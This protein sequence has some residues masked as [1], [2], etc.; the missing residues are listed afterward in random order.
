LILGSMLA[1][2]ASRPGSALAGPPA[3]ALTLDAIGS[4][5]AGV[6]FTVRV[7]A[8]GSNG[9]VKT[10]FSG[11]VSLSGLDA[12]PGCSGCSPVIAST[13]ASYGSFTWSNGVGTAQVTAK[14]AT[15]SDT[16]T[17]TAGSA[18]ADS[19]GFSVSAGAL[20]D[21][22][23]ANGSFNGQP[24]DAEPGYPI[25]SVC[26]PSAGA[27]PCGP[28][29]TPTKVQAV[30]AYGNVK[31]GVTIDITSTPS[32]V[33]GGAGGL[34][35]SDGVA[36]FSNLIIGTVGSTAV[37]GGK[38]LTATSGAAT[39]TSNAFSIVNDLSAC[40]GVTCKNNTSNGK[41]LALQRA[42]GRITTGNDF[43]NGTT[44]NV[45]LTTAFA[46]GAD[47]TGKCT[48]NT[49]IGD[50]TDLKIAGLGTGITA[51]HTTMVLVMTSDALKANGITSRGTPSFN[52]CLGALNVDPASTAT[53][54]RAK[55]LGKKGGLT[56]STSTTADTVDHRAWGVPADCGTSGLS[57]SD[58]CIGL[59]TKSANQAQTYLGLTSAEFSELGISENDLVIIIEKGAPWDGKGGV[60]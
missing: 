16:L 11:P 47:T 2:A 38:T 18:T 55:N 19:N 12:S 23:F 17:A 7:T 58:P 24:I 45:R 37:V 54:W 56:N 21:L 13:A 8:Y 31:S 14:R 59:R 3:S 6:P 43:Y 27:N 40:D 1:V 26:L 30:D 49:T 9:S 53:T 41:A 48:G 57:S 46:P 39:A 36:S 28:G 42:Y 33:T 50:S 4:Q 15:A 25:N 60:F 20:G 52:V 29:S 34:T 32:G 51:P 44:T 22:T 5:V 10:S 35:G